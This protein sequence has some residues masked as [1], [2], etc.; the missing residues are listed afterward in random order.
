MCV[1]ATGRGATIQSLQRDK[2][3]VEARVGVLE[4][5]A[6]DAEAGN[7]RVVEDVCSLSHQVRPEDDDRED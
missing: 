6:R 7:Q 1:C 5:R 3:D 4:A 2:A